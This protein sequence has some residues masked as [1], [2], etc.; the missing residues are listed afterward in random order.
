MAC[1]V[2]CLLLQTADVAIKKVCKLYAKLNGTHDAC[3]PP[4]NIPAFFRSGYI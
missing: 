3:C 1:V 2:K 4:T